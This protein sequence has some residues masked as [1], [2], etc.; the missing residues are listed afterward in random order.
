MIII[1][2]CYKNSSQLSENLITT[3][4]KMLISFEQPILNSL[5]F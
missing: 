3:K 1:F 5:I 4:N 2:D